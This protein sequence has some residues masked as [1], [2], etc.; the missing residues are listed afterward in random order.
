MKYRNN[1]LNTELYRLAWDYL[2][3]KYNFETVKYMRKTILDRYNSTYEEMM[4]VWRFK[5]RNVLRTLYVP[6]PH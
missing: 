5:C 2:T 3:G 6:V 1:N 4:N